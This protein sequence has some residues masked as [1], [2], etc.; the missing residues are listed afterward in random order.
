MLSLFIFFLVLGS[1]YKE[2]SLSDM[3][4]KSFRPEL[5]LMYEDHL[6]NETNPCYRCNIL[7]RFPSTSP[8]PPPL[9]NRTVL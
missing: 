3:F 4:K 5:T 8:P 6:G 7:V 9:K 1:I 2:G